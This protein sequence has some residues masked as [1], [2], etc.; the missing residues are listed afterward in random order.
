MSCSDFVAALD[1][2]LDAKALLRTELA[3]LVSVRCAR[4]SRT[5][6]IKEP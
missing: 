6:T 3:G 5:L 2:I 4:T 1:L